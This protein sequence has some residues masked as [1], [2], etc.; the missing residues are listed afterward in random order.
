[1]KVSQSSA[2]LTCYQFGATKWETIEFSLVLC[3]KDLEAPELPDSH[4]SQ[5]W[6]VE[7]VKKLPSSSLTLAI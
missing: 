2:R 6:L 3:P 5:K 4:C 7:K 1:V